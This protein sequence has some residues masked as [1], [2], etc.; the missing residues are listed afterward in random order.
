MCGRMSLFKP[1]KDLEGRFGIT[2]DYQ[3]ESRYNIAPGDE[4]DVVRTDDP[5]H[6]T[7]H[8]WGLVPH[9]VA[10]PDDGPSPSTSASSRVEEFG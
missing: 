9:W 7:R 5:E 8:E 4:F 6:A 10:D 3:H 2:F 1:A